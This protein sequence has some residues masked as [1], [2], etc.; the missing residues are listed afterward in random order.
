MSTIGL[1]KETLHSLSEEDKKELR[2]M[3]FKNDKSSD[4]KED[5]PRKPRFFLSLPRS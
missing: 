5:E 2:K 3:R 4:I 1:S